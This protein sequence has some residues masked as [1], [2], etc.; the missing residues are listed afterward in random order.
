MYE[1]IYLPLLFKFK[2]MTTTSNTTSNN[3]NSAVKGLLFALL[4]FAVFSVHDSLVKVLSDYSIFQII[5]FA[6]LFGYVPFSLARITSSRPQTLK[7]INLSLVLIRSVLTVGGL[8]FAFLSFSMLPM[9]ETYVLLFCTPLIITILAIIFLGETIAITRWL[10]IFLGLIGVLI[11]LR[12]TLDTVEIG[13]LY[14]FC[15]ALCS[16]GAAVI[17]RKIGNVENSATLIIFPLI[18][19]ILFT[20]SMLYFVYKPMPLNDLV[21]MFLIGTLGLIGQFLILRAYRSAPAALVAPT[22]YSQ[23][24]WAIIIGSVF[25]GESIDRYVII[26]SSVVVASG[27]LILWR[28]TLNTSSVKPNINTRNSRMVMAALLRAKKSDKVDKNQQK[29]KD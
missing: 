9:V 17:S 19:N 18:T 21:L 7:P 6:M 2:S 3:D 24:I 11:V 26:G 27:L 1:E 4:G 15:A 8:S 29:Y 23:I 12:P 14:G 25:F 22:Q 5:F 16:A 10:A 20:G 28:E 13:H